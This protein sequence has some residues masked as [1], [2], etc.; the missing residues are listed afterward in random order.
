LDLLL[1]LVDQAR[2]FVRRIPKPIDFV[3]VGGGGAAEFLD[4]V[5]LA[6]V[7]S[8][9]LRRVLSFGG[10]AITLSA[11]SHQLSA[12]SH[13]LGAQTDQLGAQTD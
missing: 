13:Q 10:G 7:R 11:H 9:Q 5:L 12:H 4:G 6:S 3:K 2:L 8:H 1:E